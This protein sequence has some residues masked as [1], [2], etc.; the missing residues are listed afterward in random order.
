MFHNALENSYMYMNLTMMN[1]CNDFKMYCTQNFSTVKIQSSIGNMIQFELLN[2]K[3][4]PVW[5]HYK[6]LSWYID[7]V[8][9]NTA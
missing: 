7:T 5:K 9:A 6:N 4:V 1:N 8:S 3:K 2:K